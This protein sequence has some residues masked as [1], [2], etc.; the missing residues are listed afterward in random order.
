MFG[1]SLDGLGRIIFT[2]LIGA[3]CLIMFATYLAV[4][5]DKIETHRRIEPTLRLHTDGNTVDTIYVY[6]KPKQ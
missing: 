6:Q 2:G 5:S 4:K 3:A 1:N